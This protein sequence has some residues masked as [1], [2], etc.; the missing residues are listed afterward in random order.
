MT[1]NNNFLL[2]MIWVFGFCYNSIGLFITSCSMHLVF[3]KEAM[4]F[5]DIYMYIKSSMYIKNLIEIF[6]KY[7]ER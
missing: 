4:R 1:S 7:F 3:F 2:C 5:V 6:Q